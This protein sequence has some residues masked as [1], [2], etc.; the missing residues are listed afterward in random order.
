LKE[1]GRFKRGRRE[2]EGSSN[3]VLKLQIGRHVPAE[4]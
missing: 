1:G 2:H 3:Q 4:K